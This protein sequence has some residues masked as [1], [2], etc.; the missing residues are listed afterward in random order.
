MKLFSITFVACSC[1]FLLT[2]PNETD[3]HGGDTLALT[4]SMSVFPIFAV[5]MFYL[6]TSLELKSQKRKNSTNMRQTPYAPNKICAEHKMGNRLESSSSTSAS[7]QYL[8]ESMVW[9]SLYFPLMG[10][11]NIKSATR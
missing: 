3:F 11:A 4:V 10:F 2:E 7:A 9:I 1:D 6:S 8:P 5:R